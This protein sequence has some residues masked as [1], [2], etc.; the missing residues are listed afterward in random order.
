MSLNPLGKAVFRTA[1]IL[2]PCLLACAGVVLVVLWVRG[3]PPAGLAQRLPV[4]EAAVPAAQA[5]TEI[6]GTFA[7]A[8]GTPADLPGAWPGFRGPKLDAISTEQVPL[9]REWPEGGPKVLWSV[10]LG[11]GYAGA[12]VLNGRVYVLD[13][14]HAGQADVLRCMSLADGRDIWRYSY[15]VEVKRNHG[16]SRTVP[17]VT[18]RYVVSLGPKCHVTCLDS[19]NGEL[20]WAID[21]VRTY[22]TKVPPWYAGQCPLI[23]GDRAIIAPGGR[24]LMIAVDLETG[25]VVWRTP[26][27]NAW[28]MTHSSVIPMEFAGKKMYVYCGS[29]GVAGISAQDGST[30]WSTSDWR[31]SI[32]TI[33]TPV[34]VGDGRIFLAGGYNAGCAMLQLKDAGGKIVPE[35]AF[36]L[37]PR[38]FGSDQQTPILYEG[39]IYGVIPGGQLACLDLQGKQLWTSGNLN[40]FG[41]GPYT[42][43]GNL[44]YVMNDTGLLTLAEASPAGYKQLA[45]AQ[46]LHGHDAW[47]PMAVAGGRLILRDMTMM[48]CL[49]VSAK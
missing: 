38:D 26:N 29:G 22:G 45:Q 5:P 41:L 33:P 15:P 40:R 28:Q 13:Y 42:I 7:K 1:P 23:D 39:H 47:G 14:D 27:L 9:A 2:V 8:D 43:I 19:T 49:D 4:A 36:R 21:L 6:V 11:E 18:E 31:I 32:A 24:A 35:I 30:L 25:T 17:A 48:V 37:K 46:V 20:K 44:I 12:A 10:E 34:I 16:M 3:G